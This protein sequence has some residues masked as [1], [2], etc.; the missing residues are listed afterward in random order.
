[1]RLLIGP[2]HPGL[3]PGTRTRANEF[4]SVFQCGPGDSDIDRRVQRLIERAE[5]AW[6]SLE[7][8]RW[9]SLVDDQVAVHYDVFSRTSP[10]AVPRWPNAD[11]FSRFSATPGWSGR[12]NTVAVSPLRSPTT[13]ETAIHAAPSAPVA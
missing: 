8:V 4:G 3:S 13:A 10:L 9:R 11:H 2:L 1:M 5:Y 6:R 12:M 7:G